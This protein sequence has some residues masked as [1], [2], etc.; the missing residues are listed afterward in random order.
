MLPRY[1]LACA[2]DSTRIIILYIFELFKNFQHKYFASVLLKSIHKFE[3][4]NCFY[5]I[6]STFRHQTSPRSDRASRKQNSMF[7]KLDPTV[8][9]N[10]VICVIMC[11]AA[12]IKEQVANVLTRRTTLK[13]LTNFSDERVTT[14]VRGR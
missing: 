10:E 6:I 2:L 4:N 12:I 11:A 8:D 13:L 14:L 7:N 9:P 1:I 5:A 3:S